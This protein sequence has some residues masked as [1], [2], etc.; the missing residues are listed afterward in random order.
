MRVCMLTLPNGTV[1]EPDDN[2]VFV[3]LKR[4]KF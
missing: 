1:M 3:D 2:E 4:R